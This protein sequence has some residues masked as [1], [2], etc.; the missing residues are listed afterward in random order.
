MH[1]QRSIL[2][3]KKKKRVRGNRHCSWLIETHEVGKCGNAV[4][5]EGMRC[6]YDGVRP[7]ARLY[8]I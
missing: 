3:M 1:D 5:A 4:L 8:R 7:N 6:M 2:E